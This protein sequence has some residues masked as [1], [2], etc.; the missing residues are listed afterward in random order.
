MRM[1]VSVCVVI[2][3]VNLLSKSRH[4]MVH[5]NEMHGDPFVPC[6]TLVW[7]IEEPKNKNNNIT[8]L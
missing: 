4:K 8:V 5:V 6:Q 7:G 2:E 3:S 1:Y